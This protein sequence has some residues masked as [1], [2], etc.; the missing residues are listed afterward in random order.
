MLNLVSNTV[1]HVRNRNI[2]AYTKAALVFKHFGHA[3]VAKIAPIGALLQRH[4]IRNSKKKMHN[5]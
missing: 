4:L 3:L 1:Y 2:R 5:L